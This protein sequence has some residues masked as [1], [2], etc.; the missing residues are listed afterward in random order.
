MRVLSKS[1]SSGPVLCAHRPA[2]PTFRVDLTES[3]LEMLSFVFQN[4]A[5]RR[6]CLDERSD[7]VP[8][9]VG[10]VVR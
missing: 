9:E 10:T 8:R 7:L 1:I 4:V 5:L 3:H 6:P 2:E